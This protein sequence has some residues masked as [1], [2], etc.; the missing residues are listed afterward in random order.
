MERDNNYGV[1]NRF[2]SLGNEGG[3]R[4]NPSVVSGEA[5]DMQFNH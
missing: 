3:G 2:T 4:V 5:P 1:N